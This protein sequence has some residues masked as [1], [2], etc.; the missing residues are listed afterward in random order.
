MDKYKL[1]WTPYRGKARDITDYA[2]D[3]QSKDSMEALSV[4]LSFT[5]VRNPRDPYI[6]VL[7]IHAGDHVQ[8]LGN[9]NEIFRGV[10]HEVGTDG[11]V[12]AN[13]LGWYMGQSTII[14]QVSKLAA[15]EVI[16][17]AC[18][19]AGVTIGHL[20]DIPTAITQI[21]TDKTPADIVK[22]VLEKATAER[23]TRYFSRVEGSKFCVYAYPT[24]PIVPMYK[25]ADNVAAFPITWRLG[26]ASGKETIAELRNTVT[27]YR[28]K[29]D[30]LRVLA[31][32]QDAASVKHYGLLQ[33]TVKA[34]D[35]AN[36]AQAAQVAKSTLS[37]LN[38]VTQEYTIDNMFGSDEVRCG[39][40]LEFH[41][42]GYIV[43]N[44]IV[45]DVTH[46]YFPT[47]TMQL[48]VTQA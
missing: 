27:V 43:G 25:P 30:V 44:F 47:H 23:A 10:I 16:R 31:S 48:G 42:P 4:E 36:R 37:N 40:M 34:E 8:L 9:A 24:D 26:D 13:D 39:V 6:G 45:T 2:S 5:V 38:R 18:T 32:T 28:D 41:S 12:I 7:P 33:H 17:K 14:L 22:E 29:D 11:S 20:P 35:D 15:S 3:L 21:Y 19:K 46:C 1:I